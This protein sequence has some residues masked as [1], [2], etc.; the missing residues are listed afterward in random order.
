MSVIEK[1]FSFACA[2]IFG[3]YRQKALDSVTM[4]GASRLTKRVCKFASH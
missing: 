3:S 2:L 4:S 1:I